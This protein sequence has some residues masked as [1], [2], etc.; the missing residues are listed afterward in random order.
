MLFGIISKNPMLVRYGQYFGGINASMPNAEYLI[1]L[2]FAS[3]ANRL[4]T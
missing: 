1:E 4:A 2:S 3:F